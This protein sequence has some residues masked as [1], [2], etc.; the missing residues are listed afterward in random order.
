MVPVLHNPIMP[1]HNCRV[2]HSL[3]KNFDMFYARAQNDPLVG[4]RDTNDIGTLI[5]TCIPSETRCPESE[6]FHF[7]P[8]LQQP[9]PLLVQVISN[10]PENLEK[11]LCV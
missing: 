2:V 7:D 4:H 5:S 9:D 6:V 3:H 11:F 8:P 1:L 10:K